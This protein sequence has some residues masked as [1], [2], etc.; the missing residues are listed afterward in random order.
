MTHN[1]RCTRA[2]CRKR[3]SLKRPL[4]S[5]ARERRCKACGGR[6]SHDPAVKRQT[7]RQTCRCDGAWFPHR[8]GSVPLCRHHE[9][10]VTEQDARD[11]LERI[12][13]SGGCH[14]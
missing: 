3:I 1:Y 10:E 6:L 4:A 8:R 14:G 7:R 11:W 12:Q 5:Y 13:A 9:G 2:R